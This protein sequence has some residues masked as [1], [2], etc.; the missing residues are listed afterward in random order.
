MIGKQ[1]AAARRGT[2]RSTR[3]TSKGER[4][5]RLERER[6]DPQ[7]RTDELTGLAGRVAWAEA[8]DRERKR[9]A[10]YRRPVVLMS[11]DVDR[12]DEVNHR[13]GHEA[14]DELLN[15]AAS[16]LVGSLRDTDLVA[17]IGGG[18]FGV[19]M[20]ETSAEAMGP[21]LERIHAACA[22][23]RGSVPEVR[24]SLSIGWATPE[25]F[26]DLQEPLRTADGRMSQG[27][28]SS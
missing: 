12:V 21:V 5:S 14:G 27:K 2:R 26:G 1:A 25:P 22:A 9:R 11:V 4:S 8:L 15:G 7:A 28:R 24:L 3:T 17:R 23:W 13:Y 10:R 6:F 16:I 18:E 20:P 19:M